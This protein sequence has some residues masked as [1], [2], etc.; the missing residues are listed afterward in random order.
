LER[1]INLDGQAAEAITTETIGKS[2]DRRRKAETAAIEAI[3]ERTHFR[4][5]I[6]DKIR[7]SSLEKN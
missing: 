5:G 3:D 2:T 7:L 6:N 1:H 4:D